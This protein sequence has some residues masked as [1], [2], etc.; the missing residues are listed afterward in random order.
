MRK[1]FLIS[2]VG[3]A[4]AIAAGPALAQEA[5][6]P[7]SQPGSSEMFNNPGITGLVST[8]P[9]R[10]RSSRREM[11]RG[12]EAVWHPNMTPSQIQ[13]YAERVVRR[14]GYRCTV[15]D[16]A[17]RAQLSDGSPVVEVHCQG[18][19]GLVLADTDPIQAT[20]CLDLPN[21]GLVVQGDLIDSCR[22]PGNVAATPR[23]DQSDMN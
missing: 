10:I 9:S 16:S 18:A 22:L 13:T 15:I 2:A 6:N 12:R 23:R 14:A 3:V 20:D 8:T 17:F 11:N 21:A 1:G 5:V 4:F 19:G 7:G